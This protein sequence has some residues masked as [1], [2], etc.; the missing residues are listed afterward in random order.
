LVEK[1]PQLAI[2][3]TRNSICDKEIKIFEKFD[4][5]SYPPARLIENLT[6]IMGFLDA[7]FEVCE[8]CWGGD[9][10]YIS[11]CVHTNILL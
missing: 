4:F 2:P 11:I 6:Q 7:A 10:K 8:L 3:D 1:S 9:R 5:C